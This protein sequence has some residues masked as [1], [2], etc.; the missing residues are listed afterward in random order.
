MTQRNR[1]LLGTLA[2]IALL[3]IYPMLASALYE[4][5]LTGQPTWLLLAYFAIAGLGWAVPAGLLIKWMARPDRS[6]TEG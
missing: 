2:M 5:W 4:R 1:K 3:I 6:S